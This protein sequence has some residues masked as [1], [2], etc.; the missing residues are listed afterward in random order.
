LLYKK[1]ARGEHES[2][3]AVKAAILLYLADNGERTFTDIRNHLHDHYNIVTGK[4]V[5]IHLLDLSYEEKRGL[6]NKKG[7]GNGKA[8]SYRLKNGFFNFKKI[9]NFLKVQSK[10]SH[11]M[12]TRYFQE[13]TNSID[14]LVKVKLNIFRNA[15]IQCY[16]SMND[17]ESYELMKRNLDYFS[18]RDRGILVDWMDRVRAKNE[19]D[20][21]SSNFLWIMKELIAGNIDRINEIFRDNMLLKLPD[22]SMAV[23]EN[24]AL[25]FSAVLVA[26]HY[27]DQI[28][29]ILRLSPGALDY[30]LN[31][32]CSN[33]LFPSDPVLAYTMNMLLP[34][35]QNNV[36]ISPEMIVDLE[37]C[38][39]YTKK[40]PRY[41]SEPP[42]LIIARSL[43]IADMIYDRLAKKDISREQF[44]LV[45]S[46]NIN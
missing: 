16:N 17:D 10:E 30:V 23:D 3:G 45:F 31:S 25:F 37:T 5:R 14:F 46:G 20:T 35:N 32:T 4:I 39:E 26:D 22:G 38:R 43:F 29:T 36:A 11:L 44:E 1:R 8:D 2:V 9:H 28:V 13:E 24:K 27:K 6:L 40:L 15:L 21:L 18:P 19:S 41:S 42:I 7:N 33:P 12:R 34:R